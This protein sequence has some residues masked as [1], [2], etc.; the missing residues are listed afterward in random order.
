MAFAVGDAEEKQKPTK[1]DLADKKDN[2]PDDGEWQDGMQQTKYNGQIM[3][4]LWKRLEYAKLSIKAFKSRDGEMM[5]LLVGITETNL[6][7]WADV[8][9]ADL[10]IN[11]KGAI[12]V[13]VERKFPLALRTV[14]ENEQNRID[15]SNWE[16]LYVE[17]HPNADERIYTQY[18]RI[19]GDE[20]IKTIFDEKVYIIIYIKTVYYI[21]TI[22]YIVC[23]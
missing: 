14:Q 10:L 19:K 13:G 4:D 8:R 11:P 18:N 3:M 16:N 21:F 7:Y 6:K 22:Y 17:Y 23:I 2:V 1:K 9:D 12:D 5:F 15:P 20:S